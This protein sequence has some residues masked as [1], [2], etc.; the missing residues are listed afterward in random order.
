MK[1]RKSIRA[2]IKSF[3]YVRV[4]SKFRFSPSEQI[5][6][7]TGGKKQ[8]PIAMIC[9]AM[10]WE[11]ISKEH[12]VISVTPSTWKRVFENQ[13]G[14]RI[15]LM[16]CE[17]TWSGTT[18]ACWRGQV[19]RDRRVFYEN[20]RELLSILE[21]CKVEGIP[22][23]FWAKEDP[24][25]FQNAI[26]DFTDTALRFDYIFTTAEECVSKYQALG[27]KRVYLWAFGFSPDIYHPPRD[28]TLLRER[29]AV[30]A[31]SWFGEYPH[32]C[33]D[34][35]A[36]F[37]MVLSEGISLC[38]YDRNRT[39]GVSKKPFPEKYQSFVRDSIPYEK[40]GDIYR[41]VEYVINVNTVQNSETMFS[42]RIYEAMACGCIVISNESQGL[43]SQFG[44]NV[45]YLGQMF[46]FENREK[47]CQ[48]NVEIVFSHHTWEKRM[49]QLYSFM[50]N[51]K[52]Y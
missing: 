19:Y 14:Q 46:D 52:V 36:I 9:D 23:A 51:D 43:R 33:K 38:I 32:R 44:D 2:T 22:S 42:R 35:T 17:A 1:G 8:L 10:T 3:L 48:Q 29:V 5:E 34:L 6:R 16:F 45:W 20:R 15:K 4:L 18:N 40:L 26:Y 24:F 47:I 39:R 49:K 27:H 12:A 7:F 30:F 41:N 31:G 28:A 37:D 25:F 50:D 13:S 11:N 21:R